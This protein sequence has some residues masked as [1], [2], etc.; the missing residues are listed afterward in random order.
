VLGQ[1]KY[2]PKVDL[3]SIGAIMYELLVGS[4]PFNAPNHIQLLRMINESTDICI[5]RHISEEA[6]DLLLRLLQKDPNRRCEFEEFFNHP[7]LHPECPATHPQSA[8]LASHDDASGSIFDDHTKASEETSELLVFKNAVYLIIHSD[9][10]TGNVQQKLLILQHAVLNLL[11]IKDPELRRDAVEILRDVRQIMMHGLGGLDDA[12]FLDL[13][14]HLVNMYALSIVKEAVS[15]ER[16]QSPSKAIEC[17]QRATILL[18]KGHVHDLVQSR[19]H[20][21]LMQRSAESR[22]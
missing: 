20:K 10:I 5:P 18:D 19:C 7:F 11:K 4:P 12:P 13:R 9:K 6:R 14:E 15:F 22:K 16:R 17:Y 8:P 3:W 21:L 2:G 1:E